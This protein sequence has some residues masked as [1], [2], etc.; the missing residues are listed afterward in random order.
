MEFAGL[1]LSPEE[2]R[3]YREDGFFIRSQVF[4]D[5]PLYMFDLSL[6]KHICAFLSVQC[7]TT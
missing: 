2:K 6:Y 4:S 3:A 1:A 5:A 7:N